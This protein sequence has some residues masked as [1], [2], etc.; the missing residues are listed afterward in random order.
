M[1]PV[2]LSKMGTDLLASL[3]TALGKEGAYTVGPIM[4]RRAQLRTKAFEC[5]RDNYSV[6]LGQITYISKHRWSTHRHTAL[7]S[8]PPTRTRAPSL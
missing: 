6:L 4:M 5:I 1:D 7:Q 8:S 3:G 2:P